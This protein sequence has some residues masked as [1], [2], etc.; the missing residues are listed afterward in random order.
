MPKKQT[1][2]KAGKLQWFMLIVCIPTLFAVI[3]GVVFLS[4]LGVNVIDLGKNAMQDIPVV[5]DFLEDEDGNKASGLSGEE[6]LEKLT[7]KEEE[8]SRLKQ[9]LEAKELELRNVQEE[10]ETL[11]IELETEG[12]EIDEAPS[13]SKDMAKIYEAMS[14]GKAAAILSEMNIE[15]ILLH[16]QEMSVDA[17]AAI[18]GKMEPEKAAAIMKKL[19]D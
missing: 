12:E 4:I 6:A 14:A 8:V 17:Q 9:E 11:Q 13:Q 16:M 7:T 18:L 10:L 5:V 2:K 15:Q 3:L 19:N 1:E